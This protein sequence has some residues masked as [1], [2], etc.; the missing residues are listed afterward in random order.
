MLIIFFFI[1]SF[2]KVF[3]MKECWI[4]SYIIWCTIWDCVSPFIL[5][6]W[7]YYMEWFS[8]VKTLLHYQKN[9]YLLSVNTLL[10]FHSI[11]FCWEFYIYLHQ[12][13]YCVMFFLSCLY[14]VLV[15]EWFWPC[16]RIRTVPFSTLFFEDSEKGWC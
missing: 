13:Y 14:L 5:L 12:G 9:F 15:S 1:P 8:Y 3:I 16:K 7:L 10:I 11:L 4:L 6:I 2:L